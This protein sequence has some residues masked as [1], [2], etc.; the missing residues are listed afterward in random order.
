MADAKLGDISVVQAELFAAEPGVAHALAAWLPLKVRWDSF[1]SKAAASEV[2][3]KECE[4][5]LAETPEDEAAA[6]DAED[7]QDERKKWIARLDK[8]MA[9]REG[10]AKEAGDLWPAW[11]SCF[12][13]RLAAIRRLMF[14]VF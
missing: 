7:A 12:R 8:A 14:F 1:A 5:R 3:V 2:K 6:M 4:A 13:L 10:A 11:V 9:D